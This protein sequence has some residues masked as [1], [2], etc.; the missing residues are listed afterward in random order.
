MRMTRPSNL[1]D[2]P[3]D[4]EKK[5]Q[6]SMSNIAN[7]SGSV[8]SV[9]LAAGKG[10]RMIGFEGNKTLLPLLPQASSL[11]LGERPLLVEVLENLPAGPKGVVVHHFADAVESATRHLGVTYLPQPVTNGT[12]GALLA[13]R[14]FL[15]NT[16][17]DHVLITMGDVPLIRPETYSGLLRGLDRNALMILAFHAKDRAQYGMLETA[18]ARVLRVIEW[19]YWRDYPPALLARLQ[20]C[21]AGVYAVRRPELLQ[22]LERLAQ[23]PH[24][25]RKQRGERWV[26]VEEYFLTD[27]VEMMSSDDL[28]VGF[29]VTGE[30]EVMGVDT[31]DSLRFAQAIY[32]ERLRSVQDKAK[33]AE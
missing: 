26:T 21:N 2:S 8:T 17:C 24:Q 20:W 3:M 28:G 10:S 14:G 31:P 25:V 15:E 11:Y 13:C 5:R 19:K 6:G 22:Y 9:V 33:L 32:C 7:H 30:E 18:E 29:V 16:P 4:A 12:G 27:L 23:Q 1:Q